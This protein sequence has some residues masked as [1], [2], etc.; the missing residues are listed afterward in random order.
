MDS[1]NNMYYHTMFVGLLSLLF[2]FAFSSINNNRVDY[3]P[4]YHGCHND[5]C[6]RCFF[7]QRDF[8]MASLNLNMKTSNIDFS[9]FWWILKMTYLI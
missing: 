3:S 9:P 5:L 8:V 4:S 6:H 7:L 1:C 2:I